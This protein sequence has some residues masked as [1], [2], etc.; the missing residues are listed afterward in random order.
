MNELSRPLLN[1][2]HIGIVDPCCPRP[3]ESGDPGD[4]GLGGT[5][6]TVLRIVQALRHEFRFT[7]FQNRRSEVR[8]AGSVVYRPL[9]QADAV[10]ML[11]GLV[12]INSW[13][14]ACRLRRR[15]RDVPVC[16]WLHVHPGRHN[17]PM[18]R[19]LHRH[20]I[21]VLC[22]SK[23]HASALRRFL[24]GDAVPVIESIYNPLA[25]DLAPDETR[26]DPDLLVFASSPHKGLREVFSTFASV[27]AE[28][29]SLRLEIADPGY[30]AWDCG[31]PPQGARFLG[32]LPHRETIRQMRKSLCLFYPQ[33]RF[34]ETFG[35]VIAEANAV[36]TPALVHRGLGANDE[37][38]SSPDQ[39]VDAA[40]LG[41]VLSA[42]R[43]WRAFAPQV[44]GRTEFRLSSVTDRWRDHLDRLLA[45]SP[46]EIDA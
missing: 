19:A 20:G 35:L 43:R 1:R 16:L 15:H 21:G 31:P 45:Q 34:A 18:G 23:S 44:A 6:A 41:A 39:L 28:I 5:E 29:P 4:R 27:R 37:V 10:G 12:V 11:D 42:I 2:R 26:R 38:V 30:L 17:R 40:D 13:K 22:V 32:T 33:T 46:M 3:Y 9:D 7:L 24:A 8:R 36:G 25:E 14:L